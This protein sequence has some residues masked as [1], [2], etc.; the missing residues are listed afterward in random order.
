MA[1]FAFGTTPLPVPYSGERAASGRPF[2][3]PAIRAAP[4]S[5]PASSLDPVCNQYAQP[6]PFADRSPGN[7]PFRERLSTRMAKTL[8]M[9][10]DSPL[11]RAFFS[12][13]NLDAVQDALRDAVKRLTGFVI[14]RQSDDQLLIVMRAIFADHA[15]NSPRDVAAEV[16]RLDHGVVT[17]VL[18]QVIS[19]ITSYLA[20]L[21]DA[22][23]MRTPIARG[24][25]T[26]IKGLTTTLPLFRPL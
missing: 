19:G 15:Q 23:R 18:D 13:D 3:S 21:R 4:F 12:E 10:A 9:R 16:K 25:A 7:V 1:P 14:D 5:I 20:Y 8:D 6:F 22:S 2:S 11:M 26:S 24:A 17:T